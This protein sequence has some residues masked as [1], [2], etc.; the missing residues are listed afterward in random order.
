ML[1]VE[2]KVASSTQNQTLSA[3]LFLYSRVLKVKIMIDAVRAKTP[4]RL[5]EA[6]NRIEASSVS[7]VDEWMRPGSNDQCGAAWQISKKG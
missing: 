2:R 5:S 7:T 4:E 6:E 1:A 3:L